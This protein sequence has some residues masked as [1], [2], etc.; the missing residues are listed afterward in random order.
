MLS[1]LIWLLGNLLEVGLL[2]RSVRGKL[3]RSYPFFYSYILFILLQSP[4]R[5]AF[6]RW[7]R[8]M[9]TNVYWVTEFLGATIGCGIVFEAYRVGLAAY[10]GTAR[11]AR[12]A[13]SFVF[14]LAVGIALAIAAGEPGWWA[15]A[16]VTEIERALRIVQ[17]LAILALALLNMAFLVFEILFNSLSDVISL[18]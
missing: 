10:P 6:Y 18:L 11:M 8:P 7:H 16:T 3:I 5:L 13:L 4:L 14:L 9:Y 12:R 1:Q 15:E 17:F 2:V